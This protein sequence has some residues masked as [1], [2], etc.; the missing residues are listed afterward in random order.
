MRPRFWSRSKHFNSPVP[1]T[2]PQCGTI[3]G[4]GNIRFFKKCGPKVQKHAQKNL[5][6]EPSGGQQGRPGRVAARPF[7]R[8]GL[9]GL[10][11]A[12]SCLFSFVWV[13]SFSS[14]LYV[15]GSPDSFLTG[16]AK[17]SFHT[18][19]QALGQAVKCLLPGLPRVVFQSVRA[20]ISGPKAKHHVTSYCRPF[21]GPESGPE[22]VDSKRRFFKVSRQRVEQEP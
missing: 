11:S 13:R 14:A 9:P 2:R 6:C 18:L 7:R 17:P 12:S 1:K 19:L 4:S 21:R 10:L 5:G 20:P 15:R 22:N 16:S 3:F 8:S